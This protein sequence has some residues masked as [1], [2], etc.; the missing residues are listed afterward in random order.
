[1]L[2]FI[3]HT[4]N[5]SKLNLSVFLTFGASVSSPAAEDLP[6]LIPSLLE[7]SSNGRTDLVPALRGCSTWADAFISATT[8][9]VH[10]VDHCFM[11]DAS[12]GSR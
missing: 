6:A 7:I 5:N 3:G 2:A 1:M 10:A 8:A 9:L 4:S 12:H 11:M